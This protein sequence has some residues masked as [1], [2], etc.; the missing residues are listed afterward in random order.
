[1]HLGL[2]GPVRGVG[3]PAPGMMQPQF[4]GPPGMMPPGMMPPRPPMPGQPMMGPPG[5]M[6]GKKNNHLNINCSFLKLKSTVY[7]P[8]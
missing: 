7:L 5:M 4:G 8:D 2:Q 6:R 3:G 1:M